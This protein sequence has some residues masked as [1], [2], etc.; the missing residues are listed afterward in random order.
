MGGSFGELY[1]VQLLCITAGGFLYMTLS[2]IMPELMSSIKK[3]TT[4]LDLLL[5]LLCISFGLYL[6][7]LIILLE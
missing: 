4:L 3:D 6:M 1:K 2:Q 5:N 7:Y